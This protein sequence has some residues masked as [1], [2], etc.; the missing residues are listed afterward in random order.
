MQLTHPHSIRRPW[1]VLALA[2]ALG[3]A[4]SAHAEDFVVKGKDQFEFA[5][6]LVVPAVHNEGTLWL[7]LATADTYQDVDVLGVTTPAPWKV[8]QDARYKNRIITVDVGPA[9]AGK[10]IEVRYRVT[11]REKAPYADDADPQSYLQP[12]RLVPRHPTLDRMAAEATRGTSGDLA[13]GRALYNHTLDRMNYD[14]SGQ[15]WGRGDA[16]HA[17]DARTGNCTDFHAYFIGLARSLGIPARFA[18]GFT[19]P[20]DADE[21]TLAGYHCWA[22]FYAEGKWIP[23]DISEADKHPELTDYYFGR[24]PANRFELSR[25]RDLVVENGPVSGPFNFLVYPVLEV[26]GKE[27]PVRHEFHFARLKE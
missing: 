24:N 18:I 21:G 12:E 20:A 15:G 13:R 6:R 26:K 2:F 10:E 14:K 17:C 1:V 19:I 25:G 7:P 8:V 23:V 9:D 16:L 11:R 27:I 3:L 4:P 5:Y 22:E